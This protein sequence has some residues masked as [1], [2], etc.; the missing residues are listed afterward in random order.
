[1]KLNR[2]ENKF[3]A[4]K[5]EM[6]RTKRH[7]IA[8]TSSLPIPLDEHEEVELW[9]HTVDESILARSHGYIVGKRKA[10]AGRFALS[11]ST[12]YCEENTRRQYYKYEE[13]S[14]TDGA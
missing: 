2:L 9:K 7:K 12:S 1:M 10:I 6:S 3:Y 8:Y 13:R 4:L 14:E 5:E 11:Q